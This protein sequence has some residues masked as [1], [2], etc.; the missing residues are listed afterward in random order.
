MSIGKLIFLGQGLNASKTLI[1]LKNN[2]SFNIVYCVPRLN[3]NGEWFDDGILSDT[4][5]ALGVKTIKI[6]DVNSNDFIKLINNAS[7][8]LLVNL[9]HHQLF[10]KELI[11][12]SHLGILNYHPGL[13]PFGRGSGATV[14]EII[15]GSNE[16]G[17]TCH[18][19]DENFDRGVIVKQETFTIDK[20]TTLTQADD[21]LM[22]NVDLFI[23]DS[24]LKALRQRKDLNAKK[25]IGFGRYFPKFSHGDDCID[26]N[27]NSLNIY[28]KIRSRIDE[29]YS[30]IYTRESL[31][32]YLVSKAELAEGMDNYISVN[33]QVID[34][35]K[36]GV[37]VKTSDTAIWITEIINP[38]NNNKYVPSFKIGTCFQTINIADFMHLL[39]SLKR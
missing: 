27:S 5:E 34:K 36:K 20:H 3:Q 11:E 1:K 17:R 30:V 39:L 25:S 21:L 38:A 32:K 33:G 6:N 35:S 18:L 31:Q 24:T 19:V 2:S 8:D 12:S 29:K 4:S 9:G 23:E 28:N 14:G 10:K 26:W 7:I 13:L 16:I 22:Q 15:N 37:L